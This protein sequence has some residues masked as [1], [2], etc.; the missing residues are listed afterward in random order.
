[1]TEQI[2][3]KGIVGTCSKGIKLLQGSLLVKLPL[4]LKY[5]AIKDGTDMKQFGTICFQIEQETLI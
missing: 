5:L 3:T 2:V 1:M 4:T